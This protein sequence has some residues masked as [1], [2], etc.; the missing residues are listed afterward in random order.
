MQQPGDESCERKTLIRHGTAS[1]ASTTG[2]RRRVSDF[3]E[4]TRSTLRSAGAPAARSSQ[5]AWPDYHP[6]QRRRS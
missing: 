3:A 2:R 4:I 1:T 6:A 5:R